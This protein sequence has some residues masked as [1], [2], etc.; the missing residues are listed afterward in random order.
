[1]IV[2]IQMYVLNFFLDE[3]KVMARMF[4]NLCQ[5][6]LLFILMTF[7][8]KKMSKFVWTSSLLFFL[9]LMFFSLFRW[10]INHYDFYAD[11]VLTVTKFYHFT[12]TPAVFVLFVPFLLLKKQMK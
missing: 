8:E 7:F 9:L 11:W 3:Y 10:L 12:R 5:A 4:Q 2:F 1:M 6:I